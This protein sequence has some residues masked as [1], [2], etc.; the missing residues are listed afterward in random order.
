VGKW[1]SVNRGQE[2]LATAVEFHPNGTLTSSFETVIESKYAVSD[3]KIKLSGSDPRTGEKVEDSLDY[4]IDGDKLVLKVPWDSGDYELNRDTQSP[5]G[6]SAVTGKWISGKQGTHPVTMQFGP[7]GTMVFIQP[8]KTANGT[9]Q[10]SG[11]TLSINLEGAAPQT[12]TFELQ[13]DTLTL[14][15]QKG[16]KI[17]YKRG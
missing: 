17:L 6:A 13:G 2:N 14:T 10:V 5:P 8:L 12:G 1:T 15:P 16:G 9:Y 11:D 7:D 4:H 3:G